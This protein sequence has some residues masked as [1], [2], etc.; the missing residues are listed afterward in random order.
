VVEHDHPVF[1]ACIVIG[2]LWSVAHEEQ[3]IQFAYPK[4]RKRWSLPFLSLPPSL[5]L[6]LYHP[7]AS[8]L[9]LGVALFWRLLAVV[10]ESGVRALVEAG[11]VGVYLRRSA[12]N[13]T[14][15]ICP[16]CRANGCGAFTFR[17][18]WP[19]RW[20]A[21]RERPDVPSVYDGA[22]ELLAVAVAGLVRTPG[23]QITRTFRGRIDPRSPAIP[24]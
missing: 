8:P 7:P 15:A 13:I 21:L 17:I 19:F 10:R 24:R 1:A 11:A 12:R 23:K 5:E 20:D 6:T 18:R 3:F 2:N 14:F 16:D 9:D 4:R 22:N